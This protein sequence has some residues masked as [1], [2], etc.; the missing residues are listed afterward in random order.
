MSICGTLTHTYELPVSS[1]RS[2][3]Y[4]SG[5]PSASKKPKV[6]AVVLSQR[7]VDFRGVQ[8][9]KDREVR[10]RLCRSEAADV[11]VVEGDL[12]AP[13]PVGVP[14]ADRQRGILGHRI[15]VVHCHRRIVDR[16]DGD[17]DRVGVGERAAGAGVTKVVW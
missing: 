6:A 7:V 3:S 2:I 15:A 14:P 9:E 12:L 8:D 5:V 16:G 17:G 11:G 10:E 13:A 4:A 1:Q